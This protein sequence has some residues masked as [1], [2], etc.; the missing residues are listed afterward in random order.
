MIVVG[1]IVAGIKGLVD[2]NNIGLSVLLLSLNLSFLLLI[3]VCGKGLRYTGMKLVIYEKEQALVWKQFGKQI[4]FSLKDITQV[5]D[6]VMQRRLEVKIGDRSVFIPKSINNYPFLYRYFWDQGFLQKPIDFKSFKSKKGWNFWV[7][8]LFIGNFIVAMLTLVV[9][10]ITTILETSQP[11][12]LIGLGILLLL[13]LIGGGAL[14]TSSNHYSFTAD[15]LIKA[16]PLWARKVTYDNIDKIEYKEFD[17]SLRIHLRKEKY[18]RLKRWNGTSGVAI[19]E[20]ANISIERI[21]MELSQRMPKSDLG[22][23]S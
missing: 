10:D 3:T 16:N 11:N 15:A 14:V 5:V 17:R 12:N 13:V 22:E 6:H 20:P 21:V 1:G 9:K 2:G 19:Q 18:Q 23:K 4:E 7:S 8:L